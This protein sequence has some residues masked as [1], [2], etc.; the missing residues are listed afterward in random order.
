MRMAGKLQPNAVAYSFEYRPGLMC[1]KDSLTIGIPAANRACDVL[2]M[3]VSELVG[4]RI[5]YAHEIKT[6]LRCTDADP[7]V[8]KYRNSQASYFRNP[9]IHTGVVL[10][11][12]RNEEYAVS[13]AQA[14]QRRHDVV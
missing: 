7:F 12:A 2:P 1:Q 10:V 6:G 11:I 9:F 3:A 8:A 14:A 5:I 13:C 4:M